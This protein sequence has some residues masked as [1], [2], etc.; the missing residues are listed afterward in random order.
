MTMTRWARRRII[1]KV[2]GLNCPCVCVRTIFIVGVNIAQIRRDLAGGLG[3]KKGHLFTS[4]T[5]FAI[6]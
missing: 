6:T 4:F 5:S 3:C 2:A 1:L